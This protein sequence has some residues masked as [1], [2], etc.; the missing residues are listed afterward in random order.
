MAERRNSQPTHTP[1]WRRR[2]DME[3]TTLR[4]AISLL[5]EA[6]KGSSSIRLLHELRLLRQ[7]LSIAPSEARGVTINQLKWNCGLRWRKPGEWRRIERD[8]AR[9]VC[10]DG[11]PNGSTETWVNRLSRSLPRHPSL[12]PSSIGVIS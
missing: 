9:T 12:R 3:I 2:L 5:H 6:R 1:T 11:T 8:F 10:S 4:R 7:R